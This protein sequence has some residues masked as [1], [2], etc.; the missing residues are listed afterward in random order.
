MHVSIFLH[1]P[2]FYYGWGYTHDRRA[3]NDSYPHH[4]NVVN[5]CRSDMSPVTILM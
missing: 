1:L 2:Y 5:D 3:D 4:R